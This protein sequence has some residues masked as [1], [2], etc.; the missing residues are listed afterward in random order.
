LSNATA[1]ENFALGAGGA[2]DGA[3]LAD[4]TATMLTSRARTT[5]EIRIL[6]DFME[7]LLL[8]V[9]MWVDVIDTGV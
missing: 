2:A 5:T 1:V 3:A 6:R 8:K 9:S 4:R 7:C